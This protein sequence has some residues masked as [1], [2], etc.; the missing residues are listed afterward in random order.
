MGMGTFVDVATTF[1]VLFFTV[2]AIVVTGFWLLVATN[3]ADVRCFDEDV[4]ADSLGLGGVPVAVS[5]SVLTALA[6]AGSLGA[7]LLLEAVASMRPLRALTAPVIFL[8]APVI[9]WWA[10]RLLVRPLRR[11][12]TRATTGPRFCHRARRAR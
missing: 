8:A 6:W 3:A 9:G 10:T 5:L 12:F 2:A 11:R 4:D 1:P 7:V